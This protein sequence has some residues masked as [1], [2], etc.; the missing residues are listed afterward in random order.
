MIRVRMPHRKLKWK[1]LI[2]QPDTTKVPEPVEGKPTKGD[3]NVALFKWPR[4]ATMIFAPN[5]QCLR[6]GRLGIAVST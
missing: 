1:T 2:W 5:S 4:A 6:D 3:D